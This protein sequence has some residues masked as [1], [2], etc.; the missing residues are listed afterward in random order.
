MIP[1]VAVVALMTQDPA[2]DPRALGRATLLAVEGDSAGALRSRWSSALRR[3]PANRTALLGLGTFARLTYDYAAADTLLWQVIE[4]RGDDA[5]ADYARM[6]QGAALVVRGRLREAADAYSAA[7]S[8]AVRRGDTTAA[9]LA[10]LGLAGPRSRLGAPAT[11]LALL[12][13]ADHL[14]RGDPALEA[15][16]HCQRAVLLSRTGQRSAAALAAEGAR[17][18][19]QAGDRRQE[20]RCLQATAQE[21]AFRGDISGAEGPLGQAAVLFREARDLAALASIQQWHGYLHI[22][23]AQYGI[24][25]S[26]LSTAIS[27]GERSGAMSPVGW[28]RINMGMISLGLGDR[29]T[30]RREL[31]E[32]AALLETQGD[33]WGVITARSMLGGV[34]RAAG[35]IATARAIYAEVLAWADRSGQTLTQLNMHSALASL[36]EGESDWPGAGREIA[37]AR[38][39]ARTHGM[40]GWSSPSPWRRGELRCGAAISPRPS[41]GCARPCSGKTPPSTATGT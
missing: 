6:E 9:A 28:A 1:L 10:L 25:R 23:L 20:A 19:R 26:T 2:L 21:L 33:Q 39:I 30:A 36:H 37:T 40:S 41:G 7:L 31:E 12:A 24:A 17:L 3:D 32:A 5:F 14:T 38:A 11:A 27:D 13:P 8:G 35:D 15:S 4:L 22:T 16:L 29:V 34:A 18:A